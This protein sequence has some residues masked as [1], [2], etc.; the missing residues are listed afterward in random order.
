MECND[1]EIIQQRSHEGR[2]LVEN[3]VPDIRNCMHVIAEQE[4]DVEVLDVN[5]AEARALLLAIDPLAQLAGYAAETLDELRS[6]HP[7]IPV[8]MCSGYTDEV[9]SDR[10]AALSRVTFLQKPFRRTSILEA[11]D[12]GLS[13][14]VRAK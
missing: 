11:L 8:V 10:I 14:S 4:V 12:L 2:Q 3:L 5:D 6:I 7:D 13:L 1:P 9:I